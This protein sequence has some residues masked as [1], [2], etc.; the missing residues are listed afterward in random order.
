M[1]HDFAGRSDTSKY[2]F[3]AGRCRNSLLLMALGEARMGQLGFFDLDEHY[4]RLSENGDLLLK[5]AALIDFEAFQPKLVTALKWSDGSKGG[6]PP[7]DPVLMFEILILQTLYTQSD[8]A[9]EW[10]ASV[11]SLASTPP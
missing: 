5:L 11:M 6:R 1:F 9:T 8:D 2:P 4:Q 7:Y 3:R 10:G